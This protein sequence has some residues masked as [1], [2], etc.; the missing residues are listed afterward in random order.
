L[1]S[2]TLEEIKR[3]NRRLKVSG[4]GLDCQK[5]LKKVKVVAGVGGF[6]LFGGNLSCDCSWV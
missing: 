3:Y 6:R 1:D 2:L 5:K 4:F